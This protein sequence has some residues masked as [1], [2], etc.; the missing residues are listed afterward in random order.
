MTRKEGDAM[1]F[2]QRKIV[3]DG[4]P[5]AAIFLQVQLTEDQVQAAKRGIRHRMARE[6]LRKL[7]QKTV[8]QRINSN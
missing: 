1:Q 5:R 2:K 7:A 8:E 4:K 3:N 6:E